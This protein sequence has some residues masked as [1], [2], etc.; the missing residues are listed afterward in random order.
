MLKTSYAWLHPKDMDVIVP[1]CCLGVRSRTN[2]PDDSEAQEVET[3]LSVHFLLP[4]CMRCFFSYAFP[5]G[6][7]NDSTPLLLQ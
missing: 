6:K 2:S 1:G 4:R 5:E 3:K 7:N